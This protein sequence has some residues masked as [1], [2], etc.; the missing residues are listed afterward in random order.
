MPVHTINQ[1]NTLHKTASSLY[2]SLHMSSVSLHKLQ[3][4]PTGVCMGSWTVA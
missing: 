2:A 4:E 1:M 3:V